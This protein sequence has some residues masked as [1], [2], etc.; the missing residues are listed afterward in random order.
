MSMHSVRA[1]NWLAGR[2][3][4]GP[5]QPILPIE[6]IRSSLHRLCTSPIARKPRG[7]RRISDKDLRE[8]QIFLHTLDDRL[9][10]VDDERWAL[11]PRLYAILHRIGAAELMHDFIQNNITD[12]NLPFN[13]QTLPGFVSEKGRGQVGLCSAF[14]AV[15]DYHLTD[16]KDIESENCDILFFHVAE[17]HIL[18]QRCHLVKGASAA[19]TWFLAV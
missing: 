9:G 19:L 1:W 5:Q 3:P 12:F 16:I 10:R 8:I 2:A 11:R 18:S 4:P 13:E 14:F 7:E 17:T 6:E 15:Q